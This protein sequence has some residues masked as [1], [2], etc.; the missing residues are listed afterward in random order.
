MVSSSRQRDTWDRAGDDHIEFAHQGH[1]WK[2]HGSIIQDIW[3]CKY[4]CSRALTHFFKKQQQ[5]QHN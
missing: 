5:L 3:R 1:S 2:D 4:T